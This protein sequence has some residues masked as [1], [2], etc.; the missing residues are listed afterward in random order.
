VRKKELLHLYAGVPFFRK[1]CILPVTG[2]IF[3]LKGINTWST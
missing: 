1:L 3:K 2:S